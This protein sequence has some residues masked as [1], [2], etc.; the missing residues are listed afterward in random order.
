MSKEEYLPTCPVCD[1]EGE[2]FYYNR[3]GDPVGCDLCVT[4]KEYWEVEAE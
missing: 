2:T 1:G 4:T 3:Y